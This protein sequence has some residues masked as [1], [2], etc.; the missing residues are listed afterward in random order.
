MHSLLKD[1]II[2]CQ[3]TR[4]YIRNSLAFKGGH[5]TEHAIMQLTDQVNSSFEKNH[6]TLGIFVDLL[7]AF[8]TVDHYILITNLENYGVNGKNL[9]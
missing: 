2:T 7:K 9:R 3:K 5:S 1:Y 6:F 8:D 4:C